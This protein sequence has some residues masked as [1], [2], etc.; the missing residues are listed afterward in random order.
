MPTTKPRYMYRSEREGCNDLWV[1]FDTKTNWDIACTIYW[2]SDP[3]WARRAEQAAR[4]VTKA[5]NAYPST[6]QRRA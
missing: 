6:K 3:R 2:D 4:L 1:I 5:L